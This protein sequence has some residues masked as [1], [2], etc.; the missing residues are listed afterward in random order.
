MGTD[1]GRTTSDQAP[2]P[3]EELVSSG[4]LW[5]INATTFHPR[6]LALGISCDSEGHAIGWRLLG[7]AIEPWSFPDDRNTQGKFEAA[8]ATMKTAI[9]A[10][11]A[12]QQRAASQ[13]IHLVEG[14][15]YRATLGHPH[16]T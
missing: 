10:N 12:E 4:L 6:G 1:E 14:M 16:T 9:E 13:S 7:S 5:L 15:T 3:F 8:Q 2:L 11:R